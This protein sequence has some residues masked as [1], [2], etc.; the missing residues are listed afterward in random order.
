MFWRGGDY[1]TDGDLFVGFH[2]LNPANETS[3]WLIH[4]TGSNKNATLA[5]K[6]TVDH[7]GITGW[8]STRSVWRDIINLRSSHPSFWGLQVRNPDDS[9]GLNLYALDPAGTWP[10]PFIQVAKEGSGRVN[11]HVIPGDGT[12]KVYLGWQTT[13]GSELGRRFG[14]F[15]EG[16]RQAELFIPAGGAGAYEYGMRV[17]AGGGDFFRFM[18]GNS[19]TA[20]NDLARIHSTIADGE[21]ALL[22]RRNVGGTE[23]LQRVSM[24]AADSGGTGYKVLRVAN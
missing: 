14:V 7:F 10:D 16:D 6:S 13:E 22:I 8:D 15:S 4:Q 5:Y 18:H 3:A 23:T 20:A 9:G 2:G 11:L 24:G 1:G 12:G 21:T 19:R 17:P